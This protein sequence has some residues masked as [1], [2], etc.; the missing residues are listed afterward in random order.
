M[1]VND[2]RV[3]LR[4]REIG[5]QAGRRGGRHRENH[6][7]GSPERNRLAIEQEFSGASLG[8][9]DVAQPRG[10]ANL[11]ALPAQQRQGRVDQA[12]RQPVMRDQCAARRPAA[13]ERLDQYPPEQPR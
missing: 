9:A 6:A 8:K 1:G 7:V 12:F 13:A 11:G 2:R 5:N 4:H 10:E 3:I